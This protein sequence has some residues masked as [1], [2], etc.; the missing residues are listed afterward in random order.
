MKQFDLKQYIRINGGLPQ[1][2]EDLEWYFI[3]QEQIA[4]EEE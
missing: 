4:K 3:A 2:Q 1:S